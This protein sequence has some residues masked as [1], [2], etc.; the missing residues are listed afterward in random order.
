MPSPNTS[1]S[2]L[3]HDRARRSASR[4]AARSRS[5]GGPALPPPPPPVRPPLLPQ[6]PAPAPVASAWAAV[7]PS[8]PLADADLHATK[9][10]QD[11]IISTFD[12][13]VLSAQQFGLI[14]AHVRENRLNIKTITEAISAFKHDQLNE[15]FNTATVPGATAGAENAHVDDFPNIAAHDN[16]MTCFSARPGW[17][18]LNE[19]Q[20]KAVT[21][22]CNAAAQGAPY[23]FWLDG[24]AGTG[25]THTV[26]FIIEHIRSNY[27]RAS[28]VCCAFQGV[29]AANIETGAYTM[30]SLFEIPVFGN[31]IDYD[32]R[33]VAERLEDC[34]LLVID[35]ISMV[36]DTLLAVVDSRM[37]AIRG[38]SDGRSSAP[39]GGVVVLCVGDFLQIPPN[40]GKPV[41]FGAFK[42]NSPFH[43]IK[44]LPLTEVM[45]SKGCKVQTDRANNIREVKEVT[46]K[47]I[48]EIK[49]FSDSDE[50][51]CNDPGWLI[52]TSIHHTNE[53]KDAAGL[54]AI[55]RHAKL[56]G[57]VVYKFRMPCSSLERAGVGGE[58]KDH[59]YKSK[60]AELCQHY[61]IGMRVMLLDNICTA[62][63]LTNGTMGEV[64]GLITSAVPVNRRGRAAADESPF[65][66]LYDSPPI[67]V[68][69]G[70]P[71]P[72]DERLQ[73]AIGQQNLGWL[74]GLSWMVPI[75]RKTL[76]SVPI[77]GG[78]TV[79]P[80]GFPLAQ[81]YALTVHKSQ[82]IT[83]PHLLLDLS[84]RA[85]SRIDMSYEMFYV[86]VTRA[87][88]DAMIRRLPIATGRE[89]TRVMGKK[90]NPDVVRFLSVGWRTM[91]NHMER[92]WD[93]DPDYLRL[94]VSERRATRGLRHE[95][96]PT[97]SEAA[98]AAAADGAPRGRGR[99]GR[100]AAAGVAVAA[101]AAAPARGRGRGRG[102]VAAAPM[103]SARGR[104]R[105]AAIAPPVPVSARG[106]GR[107]GNTVPTD[108]MLNEL[109]AD[110]AARMAGAAADVPPAA[111]PVR[112]RGRGRGA[113]VPPPAPAAVAARGR[114]RGR[115]RGAA[116]P[117][118]APAALPARGRGRGRGR[119]NSVPTDA[120][121]S[122]MLADNAA[123]MADANNGE[124]SDSD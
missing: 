84:K 8:I 68:I 51:V 49:I 64:K 1:R 4:R 35:E 71:I 65:V 19:G 103:A 9:I 59:L 5:A 88:A 106:R 6:E 17:E 87:P 100:G 15:I 96:M 113:A 110:N 25:K 48:E 91:Q 114:G 86:A 93:Q 98:A 28:V 2:A 111:A 13:E 75:S 10:Q 92:R 118:P 47:H 24:A 112:G 124:A 80:S 85:R 109:L 52:P 57:R 56:L 66:R 16:A 115:G 3:R 30:H 105:G 120:M 58:I 119:G 78:Y 104:G 122:A 123:R 72:K 39:F 31:K 89:E 7:A 53:A 22:V 82:G 54:V 116:V 101:P 21:S 60:E 121:L 34:L 81:G 95:V 44:R 18:K 42:A 32:R 97:A 43:S 36:S 83:I 77:G 41:T 20:Q 79:S 108:A 45:R 69:V 29:A 12:R 63:G 74:E 73:I 99:G 26:R 37:R 94:P 67:Y 102:A 38:D 61:F 55:V 107:G 11:E 90:A 50:V 27:G 40:T 46:K 62:L 76:D 70:F 23:V 117:P 33:Q 14:H